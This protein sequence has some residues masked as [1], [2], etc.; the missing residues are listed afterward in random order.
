MPTVIRHASARHQVHLPVAGP[1]RTVAA[2]VFLV[3]AV[4]V[5]TTIVN[6]LFKVGPSFEGL[7]DD[8]RPHLSSAQIAT[9]RADIAQLGAAGAEIQTTM[10]PA[11][12]EQLGMTPAQFSAYV[13]AKYPQVASGMQSLPQIT[14]TFNGLI[15]TLDQQRPLFRSAD[16]IP[17]KDLPATTV[18][19]GLLAAGVLTMAVG[20]VVWF[21]PRPGAVLALVLGALLVV[22]S[23][24]MSLP[25]KASDADKLNRNLK[26]VYTAAML[27]EA[28]GALATVSAMGG[29]LQNTMLPALATQLK[30]EPAQLQQ[31]LGQNFPATAAALQSMPASMGRFQ[32][33]VFA[34]DDNLSNYNTLKPVEF[35]PIIWTLLIAGAVTAALGL[36]ILATPKH[37]A[38]TIG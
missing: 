3:G 8:F 28:H 12:A 33:L 7:I 29:E 20:A 15:G 10:I 22:A 13:A 32:A 34:F 25:Q 35:V 6:N 2:L 1:R 11:M 21:S 23:L 38:V 14:T 18:P 37:R 24:V 19:W 27:T 4:L 26:P 17:T 30:M 31:F 5:G 9:A 16:A 36:V